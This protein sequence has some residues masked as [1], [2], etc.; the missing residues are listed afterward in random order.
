MI[1][2]VPT[3]SETGEARTGEDPNEEER[4]EK[5]ERDEADARDAAGEAADRRE[6]DHDLATEEEQAIKYAEKQREMVRT[7]SAHRAI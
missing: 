7:P 5:E 1:S 6:G 2:F 4:R 3:H